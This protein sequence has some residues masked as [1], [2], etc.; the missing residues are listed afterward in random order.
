VANAALLL[1]R[2]VALDRGASDR[3]GASPDEAVARGTAVGACV[4]PDQTNVQIAAPRR[5][6][7]RPGGHPRRAGRATLRTVA[8]DPSA[9]SSSYPP[10][11]NGAPGWYRTHGRAHPSH[12]METTAAPAA[13]V[14]L[15]PDMRKSRKRFCQAT[16]RRAQATPRRRV[17]GK[18]PRSAAS[19][20]TS[21]G[22]TRLPLT[23][24]LWA[25]QPVRQLL[26]CV[27]SP[28]MPGKAWTSSNRRR[29]SSNRGW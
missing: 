10:W 27:H 20:Q 25:T 14:P 24:K 7:R 3:S 13:I 12:S 28:Q 6:R 5:I 15:K 22:Q 9:L 21:S 4:V 26:A 17:S 1:G 18:S 11:T 23:S 19:A 29:N 8:F 16:L 2:A